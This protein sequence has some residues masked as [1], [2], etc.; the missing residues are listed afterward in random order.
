MLFPPEVPHI[1]SAV[2][3]LESFIT[4][5]ILIVG[6]AY[7]IWKG[8]QKGWRSLRAT[9]RKL[10]AIGDALETLSKI[11]ATTAYL[12]AQNKIGF[13]ASATAQW[14]ADSKGNLISANSALWALSGYSEHEL[15]GVG[16]RTMI[17]PEDEADVIAEWDQAIRTSAPFNTVFRIIRKDGSTL[18]VRVRAFPLASLEGVGYSAIVSEHRPAGKPKV[19]RLKSAS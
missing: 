12:E 6:G 10:S 5:L 13:E 17:H 16:W 19:S 2:E 9:W 3:L 8:T 4:K 15:F 7:T 14:K 18:P 11:Q 1:P